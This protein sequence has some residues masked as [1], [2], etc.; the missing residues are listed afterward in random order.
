[1][2]FIAKWDNDAQSQIVSVVRGEWSWPEFIDHVLCLHGMIEAADHAVDVIVPGMDEADYPA[3]ELAGKL[4]QLRET[5]PPHMGLLVL[6][7]ETRSARTMRN[8]M[9]RIY[10]A[11]RIECVNSLDAA[12]ALLAAKHTA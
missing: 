10:D 9:G 7:C 4:R 12:R 3:E 6:V 5:D 11:D 2:G 1:M 8:V